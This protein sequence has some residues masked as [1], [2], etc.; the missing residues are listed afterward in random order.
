MVRYRYLGYGVTDADGKATLDYDPNGTAIDGYTGEGLGLIDLI[1][2]TDD[3]TSISTESVQSDPIEINDYEPIGTDLILDN[4]MYYSQV[5]DAISISTTLL[6]QYSLGMQNKTVELTGSLVPKFDYEGIDTSVDANSFIVRTNATLTK[7]STGATLEASGGTGYI[8]ANLNGNYNIGDYEGDIEVDFDVI[9]TTGDSSHG[10]LLYFYES[11]DETAQSIEYFRIRTYR[12]GHN[13][14]VKNGDNFKYYVNG[15]LISNESKILNGA[16]RVGFACADGYEIVFKNFNVRANTVHTATTNTNGVASFSITDLPNGNYDFEATYERLSSN[17]EVINAIVYDRGTEAQ[18]TSYWTKNTLLTIRRD[19]IGTTFLNETSSNQIAFLDYITNPDA[20]DYYTPFAFEFDVVNI[21]SSSSNGIVYLYSQTCNATKS[22]A[23]LGITGECH[24]K[25]TIEDNYIKYYVDDEEVVSHRVSNTATSPFRVGFRLGAS[26]SI[27][28]KNFAIYSLSYN[29]SNTLQ[30]SEDTVIAEVGDTIPLSVTL[31]DA[32]GVGVKNVAV[33]LTG[34]GSSYTS[35]TNSQGVASFS[36][37]DL[38]TGGKYTFTASYGSITAE[39]TVINAMMYDKAITGQDSNQKWIN[40]SNTTVGA[41][42]TSL[43]SGEIFARLDTTT[44]SARIFSAPFGIE[45]DIVSITGTP[46][47]QIYDG[48]TI[49]NYLL[50]VGHFS[51]EVDSTGDITVLK[52]GTTPVSPT[53]STHSI[54]TASRVGFQTR[55]GTNYLT[56]KDFCIYDL[57][58]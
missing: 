14:I 47:L 29:L 49:N 2:S 22:F 53:G 36:I 37:S 57:S 26:E 48:T 38:S 17:C 19:D 46:N 56:F 39:C 28:F 15:E 12:T 45:F 8:W 1:A 3:S 16:L 25:V 42:G 7:G 40:Y 10:A 51:V 18:H 5:G 21:A 55:G 50:S 20:Y 13:K 54:S 9:S 43:D 41:N 6:D 30:F 44:T 4:D 33:T 34:G 35:N 24:V 58:S 52:D 27:K 23:D 32:Y 11:Y 31:K